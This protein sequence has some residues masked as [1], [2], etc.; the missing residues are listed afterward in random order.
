MNDP[1]IMAGFAILIFSVVI[2]FYINYQIRATLKTELTR[3]KKHKQIKLAKQAQIEKRRQYMQE[4][5][6]GNGD[7]DSYYDPAEDEGV[8]NM[9]DEED[10]DHNENIQGGN[11]RLTK[12]NI[13]MRD[14]IGL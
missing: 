12:D 2:Y 9:N 14:M 3:M 5:M 8:Q 7:Q 13:L 10:D 4:R 11:Q 6:G 1:K